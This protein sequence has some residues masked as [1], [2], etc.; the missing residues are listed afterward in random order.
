TQEYER[1]INKLKK[2]MDEALFSL[3]NVEK[4]LSNRESGG[5]SQTA[6]FDEPIR[7]TRIKRRA[8]SKK[9]SIPDRIE[10]VLPTMDETF[11]R[12]QLFERTANDNAGNPI[13]RGSFAPEFSK[14]LK[15]GKIVVVEKARGP[16]EGIYKKGY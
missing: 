7:K 16:Y 14:L 6:M 10:N 8:G 3:S 2:E 9:L 5:V 13:P 1:K 11:T 15:S 12:Q 4:T